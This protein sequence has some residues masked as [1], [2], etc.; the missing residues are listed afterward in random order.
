MTNSKRV[1]N[2]ISQSQRR[3]GK[4]GKDKYNTICGEFME[5]VKQ[6]NPNESRF[7]TSSCRRQGKRLKGGGEKH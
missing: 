2:Y 1:A 7:F 3:Q 4:Q 5:N 6:G